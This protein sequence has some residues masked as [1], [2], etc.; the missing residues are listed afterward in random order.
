MTLAV[1]CEAC[2]ACAARALRDYAARFEELGHRRGCDRDVSAA[3]TLFANP[4]HTRVSVML[5]LLALEAGDVEVATSV[6][7]KWEDDDRAASG[8]EASAAR[9]EPPLSA[10]GAA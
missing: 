9:D 3:W 6:L 8:L 10:G 1:T 4:V 7:R 5:A 2:P